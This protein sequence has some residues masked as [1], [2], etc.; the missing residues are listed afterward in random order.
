[1]I[2]VLHIWVS[3]MII[4]ISAPRQ[5][6]NIVQQCTTI[7]LKADLLFWR[8]IHLTTLRKTFSFLENTFGLLVGDAKV[9]QIRKLVSAKKIHKQGADYPPNSQTKDP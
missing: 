8:K 4:Y 6:R 9:P 7:S 3:V 2:S 1:M 5:Q